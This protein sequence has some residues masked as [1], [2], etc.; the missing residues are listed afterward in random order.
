M[1][2]LRDHNGN[3]FLCYPSQK[4][5]FIFKI[6]FLLIFLKKLLQRFLLCI[7]FGEIYLLTCHSVPLNIIIY[8]FRSSNHYSFIHFLPYYVFNVFNASCKLEY[9]VPYNCRQPLRGK[10][11]KKVVQ[12]WYF[13]PIPTCHY[14]IFIMLLWRLLHSSDLLVSFSTFYL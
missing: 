9:E 10:G 1:I 3:L 4:F 11:V 7:V 6:L 5:E 12:E 14:K 2:S 8:L 13:P